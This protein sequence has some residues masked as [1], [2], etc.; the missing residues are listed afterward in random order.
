MGAIVIQRCKQL[1][2]RFINGEL[3]I[4]ENRWLPDPVD[5]RGALHPGTVQR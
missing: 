2:E 5:D 1:L 4:I 3:L